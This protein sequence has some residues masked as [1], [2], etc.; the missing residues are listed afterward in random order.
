MKKQSGDNKSAREFSITRLTP[1]K[2][3]GKESAYYV[4]PRPIIS[5]TW[6]KSSITII[7]VDWSRVAPYRPKKPE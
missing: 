4:I 5:E 1:A 7:N 2:D 3:R 6:Y